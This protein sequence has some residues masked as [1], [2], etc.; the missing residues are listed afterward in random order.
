M[1]APVL[2][3]LLLSACWLSVNVLLVPQPAPD[4][5]EPVDVVVVL[6]GAEKDWLEP[7]LRLWRERRAQTVAVSW[8]PDESDASATGRLCQRPPAGVECFTPDPTQ[9][10]G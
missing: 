4:T 2:V 1:R 5:R 6:A 3:V 10:R 9:T 7:R 8:V